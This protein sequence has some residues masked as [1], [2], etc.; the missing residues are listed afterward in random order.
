MNFEHTPEFQKDLKRL[1]KKWRSLPEDVTAVQRDITPLYIEQDGIDIG[2]LRRGVFNGKRA[3]V[4]KTL[5]DETEVVKM[6]LDVQS[7]GR[8]DKV[9]IVFI[10]VRSQN[11]ITFIELYAKNEK[12]REDTKRIKKYIS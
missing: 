5:S 11:T 6:R 12:S 2:T 1:A 3:T 8:A 10:A 4:L 7:I 9:R